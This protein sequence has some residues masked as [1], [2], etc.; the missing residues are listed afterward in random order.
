MALMI[1]WDDCEESGKGGGGGV[2]SMWFRKIQ[3][4][5]GF[6]DHNKPDIVLVNAKEKSCLI[7]DI[8]CPFNTRID[9]KERESERKL[10]TSMT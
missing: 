2:S 6:Q 10:I 3:T 8:S 7:I 4:A 5:V 1:G 9:S